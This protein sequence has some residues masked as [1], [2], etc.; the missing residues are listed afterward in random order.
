M[1]ERRLRSVGLVA[2]REEQRAEVF[3]T[4]AGSDAHLAGPRQEFVIAEEAVRVVAHR[5]AAA[6]RVRHVELDGQL[7]GVEGLANAFVHF[8]QRLDPTKRVVVADHAARP[9]RDFGDETKPVELLLVELLARRAR[10]ARLAAAVLVALFALAH[11]GLADA[12]ATVEVVDLRRQRHGAPV[13]VAQPRL[14]FLD[15]DREGVVVAV[16]LPHFV[17]GNG[18]HL[19]DRLRGQP[20]FDGFRL[21]LQ[22]RKPIVDD[23]L[24][25]GRKLREASIVV[26]DDDEADNFVL[27]DA[28]VDHVAHLVGD[29][30]ERRFDGAALRAA[31]F[32]HRD[33]VERAREHRVH[34]VRGL[35]AHDV[36]DDL[37]LL[38]NHARDKEQPPLL[39]LG[40]TAVHGDEGRRADHVGHGRREV[41]QRHDGRLCH[42]QAD[43]SAARGRLRAVVV[44]PEKFEVL[45]FF[46]G[47]LH[48]SA[49]G[50]RHA[51]GVGVLAVQHAQREQVEPA[52]QCRREQE[53]QR[54]V[55]RV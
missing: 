22:E 36:V 23:A 52:R 25:I 41:P 53:R 38:E 9:R 48:I 42:Q 12:L 6:P 4:V 2:H 50:T 26:P 45:Q 28:D 34:N 19:E 49:N 5:H 16:V 24:Q 35:L 46:G 29:L 44:V 27:R 1:P 15:F 54:H 8:H 21:G 51:E 31:A 30:L 7:L 43:L 37:D 20:R 17:L 47:E 18:R 10:A 33:A 40:Q 39:A 13:V 14:R 3:A 11:A 32:E 55:D